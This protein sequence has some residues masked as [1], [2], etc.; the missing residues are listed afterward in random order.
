MRHRA[1]NDFMS[2]RYQAAIHE[3][4]RD[5]DPL[6]DNA[7]VLPSTADQNRFW[8]Q[9]QHNSWFFLPWHRMYLGYFEQIVESIIK[10]MPGG[11]STWSLPYWNYSDSTNA[12]AGRL[13]L[14]FTLPKMKD[15]KPNPL[16]ISQ[17][18]G[19]DN[20]PIVSSA[21]SDVTKCLRAATFEGPA[22]AGLAGFGGPKTGFN[23]SSGPGAPLGRVDATPHGSVHGSVGGF[24]GGF[25]GAF[26]TAA[27]DPIFWLHH[28]NIDRLWEVWLQRDP[29]H[30]NPAV[31]PWRTALSFPFNDAVANVVTLSPSDVINTASPLFDYTYDDVSDPL[32]GAALTVPAAAAGGP[33]MPQQPE[34][35]GASDAPMLVSG[36]RATTTVRISQPTGPAAL[37]AAATP[38][39]VHLTIENVTGLDAYGNYAVY[40]NLPAGANPENHQDRYAGLIPMFG[41]PEAT[42]RQRDHPGDGL[43]FS[44]DITDLARRLESRDEWT[45]SVSVTLVRE[46][47]APPAS[48][49]AA[50]TDPIRIGR[51]GVYLS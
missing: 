15:G 1:L 43:T 17:R 6:A 3:Y 7:D 41:V 25:M 35:V 5:D 33:V 10:S 27:L 46:T 8:N 24:R 36:E 2:W 26:N 50:Q 30:V 9:C 12:S 45:G 51:V 14:A 28:A 13:P 38:P 44:L 40:V 49:A 32:G 48:V 22:V 37:R 21:A 16:R 34:M 39:D 23:H 18:R 4:V 42:R 20:A 11:P 47:P 29:A 31:A 19:N